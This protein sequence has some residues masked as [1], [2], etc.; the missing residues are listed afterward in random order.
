MLRQDTAAHSLLSERS[1]WAVV[2]GDSIDPRCVPYWKMLEEKFS[3]VLEF[4]KN[5]LTDVDH[6]KRGE[7]GIARKKLKQGAVPQGVSPYRTLGVRDAAFR[8][9]TSNFFGRSMLDK[10][11]SS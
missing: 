10:L 3:T 7:A 1:L 4:A 5:I 2:E 11:F 9:L 8:D 6:S